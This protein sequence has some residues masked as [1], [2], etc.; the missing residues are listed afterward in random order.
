MSK[1]K[2]SWIEK[3]RNKKKVKR[4]TICCGLDHNKVTCQG[5]AVGSNPKKKG[6]RME[7]L[8]DGDKSTK[9]AA[10]TKKMRK[11]TTT[12]TPSTSAPLS[13][14]KGEEPA[15]AAPP[16][17][18]RKKTPA[19]THPTSAGSKKKGGSTA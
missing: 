7:C 9:K 1:R 5:G 8:V 16:C 14:S 18:S 15:A 11:K 3:N 17:G 6:V 4:C 19:T 12:A 2:K 13:A 10:P